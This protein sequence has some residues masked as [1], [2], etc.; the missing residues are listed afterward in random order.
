MEAK[1]FGKLRLSVQGTNNGRGFDVF[2][3]FGKN[4]NFVEFTAKQ[5]FYF[6]QPWMQFPSS[7]YTDECKLVSIELVRR[8]NEFEELERRTAAFRE[9]WEQMDAQVRSL[10][11]AI[12]HGDEKHQQWLRLAIIDHF[13]GRPVQRE[14]TDAHQD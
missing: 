10:F 9:K 12:R 1:K 3:D 4:H 11:E 8:F 7:E 13:E 6:I 2:Y 5:E 14:I